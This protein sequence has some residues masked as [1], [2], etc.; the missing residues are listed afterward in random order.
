M[1]HFVR[2]FALLSALFLAGSMNAQNVVVQDAVGQRIDTFLFKNML[3]DGVYI[4]NT[5]WAG[6]HDTIHYAGIGTFNSNGYGNL[7]ME[8]GIVMTSGNVSIVPGP[9]DN[10]GKYLQTNP[11]YTDTILNAY[12]T[13]NYSV[14]T[15]ATVDFDFICASPTIQ[16]QYIFASE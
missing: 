15:C 7:G 9:N 5:K 11:T 14:T 1:K 16:L 2:I 13:N 10:S 6:T 12:N 4:Y 3:G 8:K